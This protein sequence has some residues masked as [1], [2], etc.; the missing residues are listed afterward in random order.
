MSSTEESEQTE[1]VVHLLELLAADAPVGQLADAPAPERARDLALRIGATRELHRRRESAQSSLLDIAR[2]LSTE[3]E[4]EVVL[5]AIVRRAR[6][7][8]GTD[9]AYLTLYDPEAGDTF[10]KVTDGSVS[11]DFQSLR[12]SLGD[13]L[14]GLVASTRKP[15]W[16]ADYP[17]DERFSHTHEID[18]GVG[19]EG[20]IAICGTPLIVESNFVGVLFAANRSPRPFSRFEVS[21]LGNLA[22]LAAVAIV[23]TRALADARTALSAL[24]GAHEV[25]RQQAVGVERA[26]AA[27]DRFADVVLGGGGVDEVTRALVELLGGWAVLFDDGGDRRGSF[28]PVPVPDGDDLLSHP[29]VDRA[30]SDIGRVAEDD[31][32]HAIGIIAARS[33]SARSSSGGRHAR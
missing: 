19:D 16:T 25:V 22:A 26:A 20:I 2:E 18:H 4:P 27:H 7:L 10:M 15:Y 23:Q 12:L 5:E 13:G 24:S 1:Q 32:V 28:G 31:G 11:A 33:S 8:I 3:K 30:R 29:V 17:A 6:T 9:L 14:G 21:L